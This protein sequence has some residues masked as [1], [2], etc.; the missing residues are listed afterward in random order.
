MKEPGAAISAARRLISGL[1]ERG[2]GG[3]VVSPGSRNA[4]LIQAIRD[5]GLPEIVALDERSAA[6]HALGMALALNFC[7]I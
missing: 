5:A 4:P 6:H 3:A 2:L 1:I 7:C